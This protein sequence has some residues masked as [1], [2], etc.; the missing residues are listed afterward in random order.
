MRL[1]GEAKF[2]G[3]DVWLETLRFTYLTKPVHQGSQGLTIFISNCRELQT[4]STTGLDTPDDSVGPDLPLLDKKIK[5]NR[6]TH[7]S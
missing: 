5:L 4:Q 1:P 6:R 3:Q 2:L 7:S